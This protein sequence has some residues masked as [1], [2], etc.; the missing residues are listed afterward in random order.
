MLASES[1]TSPWLLCLALG[2][3]HNPT[4]TSERQ[5]QVFS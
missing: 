5:P 1:A 2:L 3:V 4:Q